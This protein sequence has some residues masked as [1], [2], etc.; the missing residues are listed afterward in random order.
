M[1]LRKWS[2]FDDL[3]D[4]QKDISRFF[5]SALGYGTETISTMVERGQWVPA[6]DVYTKDGKLMVKT[7]VPGVDPSNINV[8]VK[9]GHLIITGERKAE[10]KV[11]EKDVYRMESS[12]GKFERSIS[13]PK[14]VEPGNI[15]ATYENG[16]LTIELPQAE[17]EKVEEKEIPIEIK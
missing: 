17:E 12:Y 5:R 1:S 3:V 6:V 14:D 4:I 8:R 2:P 7:Q 15:K 10:E 9:N 11:E 13:L 16:V